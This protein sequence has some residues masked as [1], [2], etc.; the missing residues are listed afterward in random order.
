MV[1]FNDRLQEIF[2]VYWINLPLD[3]P[4]ARR[5]LSAG[6]AQFLHCGHPRGLDRRGAEQG[7]R[8][9]ALAGRHGHAQSGHGPQRHAQPGRYRGGVPQDAGRGR[10][11][12]QGR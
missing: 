1:I 7:L 10:R 5:G 6:R 2:A 12:S 4:F 11:A 9:P 3:V 8:D